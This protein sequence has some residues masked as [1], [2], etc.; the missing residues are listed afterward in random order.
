VKYNVVEMNQLTHV[1]QLDDFRREIIGL[2]SIDDRSIFVLCSHSNGKQQ[3][4]VYDMHEWKW[5]E[6][7]KV[8]GLG[9]DKFNGLTSC[10]KNMYLYVSDWEYSTVYKIALTDDRKIL[11]WKVDW[12]PTGLSVNIASNL[13]VTC[14]WEKTLQEF[15]P[16]G[17]LVRVINLKNLNRQ[18]WHS[19]ELTSDLFLVCFRDKSVDI[20]NFQGEIVNKY[21]SQRR[22]TT[23]VQFSWP[24]HLAVDIN[25]ERIFVADSGTHRIVELDGSMNYVGGLDELTEPR[26]LYFNKSNTQ[27]FVCD[28]DNGG[29]ICSFDFCRR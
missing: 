14:N 26:C 18:P 17:S 11:H 21:E 3:I 27:L 9:D 6:T 20:V 12:R 23:S 10:A 15:T 28:G 29:R 5:Q 24:R 13:L 16:Q 25:K 2:T 22:S 8:P 4:E 7:L 1:F 19:V